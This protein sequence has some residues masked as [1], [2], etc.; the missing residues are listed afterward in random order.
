MLVLWGVNLYSDKPMIPRPEPG[1]A[2][3]CVVCPPFMAEAA[4]LVKPIVKL[5]ISEGK[6]D[7]FVGVH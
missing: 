2:V 5:V 4:F 3:V 6:R 1:Q 7:I